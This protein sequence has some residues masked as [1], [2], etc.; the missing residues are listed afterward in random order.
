MQFRQHI[1]GGFMTTPIQ[2]EQQIVAAIFKKAQTL[3]Q[4]SGVINLDQQIA[5]L[6]DKEIIETIDEL[7]ALSGN[8]KRPRHA[9]MLYANL[10]VRN[11]KKGLED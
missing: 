2:W 8:S 10:W 7:L 3:R 1:A 11:I 6:T 9:S 5:K 4:V